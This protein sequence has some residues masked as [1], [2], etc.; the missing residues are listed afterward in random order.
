MH[1][2]FLE[3]RNLGRQLTSSYVPHMHQTNGGNTPDDVW[4]LHPIAD[5]SDRTRFKRTPNHILRE[6]EKANS[7]PTNR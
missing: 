2:D 4:I 1:Y 5:T 3:S 7:V 6:T